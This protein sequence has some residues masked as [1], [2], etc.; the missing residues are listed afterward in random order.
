MVHRHEHALHVL[1][2]NIIMIH[3]VFWLQSGVQDQHPRSMPAGLQGLQ[4]C[5]LCK[6]AL[7]VYGR[8]SK[9]IQHQY[10]ASRDW[11]WLREE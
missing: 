9:Q 2:T 10:T 6:P 7:H 4:M 11:K 8:A 1:Y 3:K 5:H